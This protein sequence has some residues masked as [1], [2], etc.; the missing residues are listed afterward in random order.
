SR[1]PSAPR[2]S[3]AGT[4]S[5]RTTRADAWRSAGSAA[6]LSSAGDEIVPG[7]NVAIQILDQLGIGVIRNAGLNAHRLNGLVRQQ[8]PDNSRIV[9][10]TLNVARSGCGILVIAG[11]AARPHTTL[12]PSRSLALGASRGRAIRSGASTC[13]RCTANATALPALTSYAGS[14]LT[15]APALSRE[16]GRA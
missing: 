1:L 13:L 15:A 8:L 12:S 6:A 5:S 14:A 11:T 10:R 16:I 2:S 7:L 4:A 3:S 9:L